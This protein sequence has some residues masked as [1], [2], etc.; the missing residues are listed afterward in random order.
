MAEIDSSQFRKVLGCFPTGVTVVACAVDDTPS[1]MVIGSFGS[2]SLDPPLVQFMPTKDAATWVDI[3]AAGKFCVNILGDDQLDVSNAFFMKEVD[4]F[5]TV[6]WDYTDNGSPRIA[7]CLGWIDCDIQEA[8]DGGD[9]WIVLGRVLALDG[10][11]D[12]NPLLFFRGGYGSFQE[13]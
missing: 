6:E 7:G 1:A 9:H 13:I 5:T 4:P 12:G 10:R 11:D 3:E 8:V 2:V